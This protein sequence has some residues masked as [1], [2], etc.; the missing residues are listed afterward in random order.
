MLGI[1]CLAD[2]ELHRM[3]CNLPEYID[4]LGEFA[5]VESGTED[6]TAITNRK[7]RSLIAEPP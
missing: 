3:A 4:I 6:N 2:L 5:P 1:S 7:R